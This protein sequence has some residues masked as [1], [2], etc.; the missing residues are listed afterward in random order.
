M[1]MSFRSLRVLNRLIR[2]PLGIGAYRNVTGT[3]VKEE[4]NTE[5]LTSFNRDITNGECFYGLFSVL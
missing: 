1:D 3:A 5:L 4:I 2:K